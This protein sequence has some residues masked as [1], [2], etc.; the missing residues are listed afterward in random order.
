[1]SSIAIVQIIAER[2][3]QILDEGWTAEHDDEHDCGSLAIAAACYAL[4]AGG[5]PGVA[6]A[7]WPW[8]AQWFKPKDKRRDL[9]RA[10]ALIIAEIERLDR[11]PLE[12]SDKS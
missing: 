1:M 9:I 11:L 10:A 8:A 3:R 7:E 12:A 6:K 5:E 2:D 4:N